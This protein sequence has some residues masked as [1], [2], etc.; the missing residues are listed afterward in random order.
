[1][2]THDDRAV[3][4]GASVDL[5]RWQR[6][7][8][9]LMLTIGARFGRVEPRRRV[10]SFLQGL[11]AGLPRANCWTIAE[12]AGEAT[13]RGM[14]RLLGSAVV[15]AGGLR[16][17]LRGYVTEHLGDPGAVLIVDE[18]GDV[19]KGTMTA[20]VQRQYTGTAGR[21]ENAQVAVYL[22]YAAERGYAF[23]DRALYLP[24]SWT[25]D[26]GRC[27]VAGVPEEAGFATKP[28][29]ALVMI[30]RA[31]T[32]GTPARWAAGDEVY[33]ND[34]KLRAGIAGHGLGFVLAVAK[35]HR[36]PTAA[37]TRRAIDLA[38]C[39]PAC[40]WQQMSAGDGAKGPR[41][42]D[43]ALI[44]TTDPALPED[45]Q[46]ANWLLVRRP[47]RSSHGAKAEYAF[48][49]AHAPG[50][51][52]LRALVAVAGTRWKFEEGF[53]G[54]KEL[55]ALDQHQVRTWTSWMR[56]T[57][58]AMLAHAFLSVMTAAQ[59]GPGPGDV[60]RDETGHELIPLTRNEIRRL[61]T[62]LL[63]QPCPARHQLHWSRWR[64][65]HQ[66][67]ARKCHYQRRQALAIT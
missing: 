20:G 45:G 46:G 47:V 30:T 48:Y 49:R 34:P 3:A 12:H 58:L 33:G 52:P 27:R 16:D 23:I 40:A 65:R 66:A 25:E 21:I 36:I 59:P 38:V 55:T 4:A 64:R 44:E 43:W 54:S 17:D 62:G 15:D 10:R 56:W 26:A 53:A 28:A 19:K 32:A 57:I 61:F 31:V 35:D 41:L 5:D 18:T 9:E 39:L 60:H 50:L 51:V 6:G 11:L 22:A 42:Y 2:K 63:H 37:G 24:R 8:D 1:V 67:T 14:Q 13:P 7:L 29:L